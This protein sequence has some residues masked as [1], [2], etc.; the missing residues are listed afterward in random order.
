MGDTATNSFEPKNYDPGRVYTLTG[1]V[2]VNSGRGTI[3]IDYYKG[4]NRSEWLGCA[5]ADPVE[6]KDWQTLT[7]NTSDNPPAGA[8][9]IT[10][11]CV[12]LG[13]AEA[14]FDELTLLVK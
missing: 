5:A 11:T 3:R 4:Y 7:V 6:S 13:D 1:K 14:F 12:S 8:A 10:A 2:R 9:F